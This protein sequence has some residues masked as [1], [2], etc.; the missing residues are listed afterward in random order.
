MLSCAA[1]GRAKLISTDWA[2]KFMNEQ[3]DLSMVPILLDP[4]KLRK[5]RTTHMKNRLALASHLSPINCWLHFHQI[6]RLNFKLLQLDKVRANKHRGSFLIKKCLTRTKSRKD[7]LAGG[8]VM[9]Q[10]P[11]E[12]WSYAAFGQNNASTGSMVPMLM[13]LF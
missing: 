6:F 12:H 11:F 4:C 1:W 8:H 3:S 7:L 5:G 9:F 2:K 10:F 13:R